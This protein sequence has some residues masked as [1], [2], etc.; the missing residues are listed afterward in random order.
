MT[1]FWMFV[2][3]DD[4]VSATLI[5]QVNSDIFNLHS[6]ISHILVKLIWHNALFFPQADDN[7]ILSLTEDGS[8]LS[9][10]KLGRFELLIELDEAI[11]FFA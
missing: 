11:F 5:A 6:R 8:T 2:L 1:G 9:I 7:A 10:R 3:I 4:R